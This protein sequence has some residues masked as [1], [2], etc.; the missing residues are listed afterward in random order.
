MQE[1]GSNPTFAKSTGSAS[2]YVAS[3]RFGVP[4]GYNS[5]IKTCQ[6]PGGMRA[7]QNYNKQFRR[8]EWYMW[9]ISSSTVPSAVRM[10]LCQETAIVAST[11][12]QLSCQLISCGAVPLQRSQN[13][14]PPLL[15]LGSTSPTYHGSVIAG[16][17]CR[18]NGVHAAGNKNSERQQD[19]HR[20][21]PTEHPFTYTVESDQE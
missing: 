9:C 2:G 15:R 19:Q 5:S 17:P 12:M 20:V 7:S 3:T 21:A 11:C 16:F 1:G 13:L 8:W 6:S 4:E 18:E 14:R 10:N